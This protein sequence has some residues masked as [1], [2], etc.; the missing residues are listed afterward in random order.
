MRRVCAVG[1]TRSAVRP[2]RL[3]AHVSSAWMLTLTMPCALA[4]AS[5]ADPLD[6]FRIVLPTRTACVSVHAADGSMCT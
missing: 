5:Y 4:E 2:T 6:I 3:C 1:S